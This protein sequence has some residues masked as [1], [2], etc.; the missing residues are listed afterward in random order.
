MNPLPLNAQ[1]LLELRAHG[2]IPELPVLVSLIGKL[3]FTNLTLHAQAGESCDWHCIAALEV[4]LFV[5]L[6]VPFPKL[7]RTLADIAAAVPKRMILTF[8]EG[9]CVDCGEMRSVTDFALF[10]WFP[11]VV[12][13]R[14]AKPAD[15]IR[16]WNDGEM[17]ARKLWKALGDTLP[18]PYDKAMDLVVQ[19][20]A[21]NQPCA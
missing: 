8:A 10:D 9:A 1:S 13:P 7:L 2:R 6:A 5:S 21:E 17:I 15:H 11:M 20:A 19:I 18:I 4:E 16:A 14:R 3:E 12:T